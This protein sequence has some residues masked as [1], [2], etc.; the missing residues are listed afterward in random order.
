[1]KKI[2]RFFVLLP[3]LLTA[4]FLDWLFND[5]SWSAAI[6]SLMRDP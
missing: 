4:L 3:F 6:K 5:Y 2:I 1:M